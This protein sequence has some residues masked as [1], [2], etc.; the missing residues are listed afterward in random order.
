MISSI[1]R[2]NLLAGQNGV[3]FLAR[4]RYLSEKIAELPELFR[5]AV[6]KLLKYARV[7]DTEQ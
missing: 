4:S 7:G 6:S 3:R 2:I 5:G 1:V